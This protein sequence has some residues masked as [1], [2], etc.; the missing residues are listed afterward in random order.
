MYDYSKLT[1]K[2]V[3]RDSYEYE[4]ARKFWNRAI[5]R[6]PLVIVYCNNN[7]DIINAIK[8]ARQNEVPLRIRSGRHNYEGFSSGNDVI[9]I[10][11]SNMNNI[12]I[13]ESERKVKLEA[14]VKNE[15][16]YE[17]L[18]LK[19]YPFPGGGCPTVG[20]SGLVLNGGW[21]YSS[22]LF[23]LACD[24]LI[25]IEMIN[26]KGELIK[27]NSSENSDLLWA[28]K[29]A[30]GGNYGVITSMTFKLH[31]KVDKVT[32]INID[33]PKIENKEIISLV[34]EWQ[35]IFRD[36][37]RG[38]NGKLSI[39]N[40]KEKGIGVKLTSLYYGRVEE[41]KEIINK[42]KEKSSNINCSMEYLSIKE[43]NEKIEYSHPEYEIYK[44]SGRFIYKAL[45]EEDILELVSVISKRAIGSIY[46]AI[47]LYG[48]GGAVEDIAPE[49]TAF[50]YRN[51]KFILGFQTLWEESKYADDNIKWYNKQNQK[52]LGITKGSY[53]SFPYLELENFER[54]YYGG[55]IDR[56][57][58]IKDKYDPYN[59]FDFPQG[60]GK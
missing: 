58:K 30:G 26:Y 9:V 2:V 22:R 25:E 24:S 27:A 37:S 16:V 57:K 15:Q 36:A 48:L 13:N 55:N 12:E 44:S 3:T 10:D 19:N 47:T 51:A 41:A 33:F 21:G 43:A 23:G 31:N 32:L 42:L 14:G 45:N 54:E 52:V 1:G 20:V 29:G 39:Y 17:A 11:V 40:S 35:S 50:Y 56:I 5:E 7:E 53:I 6:Y 4:E 59:I 60:I 18:G 34:N 46:T 28:C 8:W 38:F 49:D